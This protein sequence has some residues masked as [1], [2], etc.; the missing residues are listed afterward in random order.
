MDFISLLESKKNSFREIN[1]YDFNPK[2]CE[3]HN[4]V[5][6]K[7]L[8]LST[9]KNQKFFF[10]REKFFFWLVCRRRQVSFVLSLYSIQSAV[11]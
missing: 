9:R 6:N 8:R 10:S 11:G 3:Q 4:L 2:Y 1:K 5:W 7:L